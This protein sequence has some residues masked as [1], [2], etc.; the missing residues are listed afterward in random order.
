MLYINLYMSIL[1]FV[2][3]TIFSITATV[4]YCDADICIHG[5]LVQNFKFFYF[6]Y[7]F[8]LFP[9]NVSKHSSAWHCPEIKS[10]FFF[11]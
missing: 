11:Y 2:F 7:Y 6:N 8:C 10:D 4:S 9:C 5:L 3:V 1:S